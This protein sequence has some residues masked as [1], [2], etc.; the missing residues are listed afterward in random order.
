MVNP[1]I[2]DNIPAELKARNQWVLWKT[3]NRAGKLTKV[4]FQPSGVEADSTDLK[5][6]SSYDAVVETYRKGGYD[7]IGY[8][9]DPLDPYSGVDLDNCINA[10]GSIKPKAKAILDGLNTY[11]EISQSG[12]GVK[13]LQKAKLPVIIKTYGGK[14]QQGFTHKKP[15]LEFEVY[16]G[17]RF[18]AMTGNRLPD[19]PA[20]IEDRN[21][22]LTGIFKDIFKTRGYFEAEGGQQDKRKAE[23]KGDI[24]ERLQN[25]FE[26]DPAFRAA[27]QTSAPVGERSEMEYYLCARL[28]EEGFSEDEIVSILSESPQ[29]KWNERNDNYRQTTVRNAIKRAKENRKKRETDEDR[30]E[31]FIDEL[32]SKLDVN[33]GSVYTTEFRTLREIYLNYPAGWE[34]VRRIL[35]EAGIEIRKLT[36]KIDGNRERSERTERVSTSPLMAGVREKPGGPVNVAILAQ[37]LVDGLNIKRLPGG[38]LA[39]YNNGVYATDDSEF[40]IDGVTRELLGNDLNTRVRGNLYLHLRALAPAVVYDD[41]ETY[42]HLICCPSYVVDLKTSQALDHSPDY[43]MLHKTAV[44]YKPKAHS[45]LWETKLK[46][47]IPEVNL[48]TSDEQLD[49]FEDQQ[50]YYKTEWGYSATGETREEAFF[51]HQGPGGCGKNTLTWA[52]QNAMGS[53]VQQVDPN[54]LVTKGD[55]HKPDYE[56]ANGVGKRIFL[57]NEMKEGGKLN[58]QLVKA[59]ATDGALFNARQIREKPFTYILRAKTHLVV[60]PELEIDEQDKAIPRRI[61]YNQYRQDFTTSPDVTLKAQLIRRENAEGV[62]AWM[63][64]GAYAYYQSGLKRTKASAM[65]IRDLIEESDPLYGFV[66]AELRPAE[67]GQVDSKGIIGAY[68]THCGNLRVNTDKLDPR[69]FGKTLKAQ[70][71]MK[72]WKFR[73]HRSNGSTIY[74]GIEY[75]PPR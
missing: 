49:N 48:K 4:P 37:R 15:D 29:T 55:Y 33:P 45:D 19:Y 23:A 65:A 43:L 28:W 3:I 16:Y 69:I 57:T 41:F 67:S 59:L 11:S 20:T 39:V 31:T 61:H 9:F 64:E 52:I 50:E 6:W 21:N 7:G 36:K 47:I 2:F 56:L 51:V 22:E 60:N 75:Q 30:W 14:I 70:L 12:K 73:T 44:D 1:P 68:K 42:T 32:P 63:V 27:Y 13:T 8:V 71:K 38:L 34:R 40:Y 5:T 26:S 58:G 17:Y 25:L 72:G 54:I 24:T 74:T 35:K 53:Y 18:F 10:D 46:E 66:D 62:L